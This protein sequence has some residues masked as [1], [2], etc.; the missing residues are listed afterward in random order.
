[1]ENYVCALTTALLTKS[2]SKTDIPFR[3]STISWTKSTVPKSSPR[4][5]F[6]QAIIKYA[7]IQV[8]SRRQLS[9]LVWP[10]RIPCHAFWTHQFTRHLHDLDARY[11]LTSP[12]QVCHYLHRRHSGI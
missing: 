6:D 3:A 12:R 11:L 4:L 8:T 5:I 1:M 2:L 9:A 10:L 7:S